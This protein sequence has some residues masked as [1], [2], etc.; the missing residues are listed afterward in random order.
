MPPNRATNL[1]A[2]DGNRN[3]HRSVGIGRPPLLRRAREAAALAGLTPAVTMLQ[4]ALE[5]PAA[6]GARWKGTPPS[7]DGLSA[8]RADRVAAP[9]PLPNP[10]LAE[11]VDG[12]RPRY[13]LTVERGT[14]AA[15][16]ESIQCQ[17]VVIGASADELR[18]SRQPGSARPAKVELA[19]APAETGDVVGCERPRP[20]RAHVTPKDIDELR[21]FIEARGAEQP[22]DSRDPAVAHRSEF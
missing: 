5:M 13:E 3:H 19:T 7:T 20:H 16:V 17:G 21:Q 22:S 2:D 18:H 10:G 8:G 14:P 6:D 4:T 1:H 11:S 9:Q 15:G 12:E